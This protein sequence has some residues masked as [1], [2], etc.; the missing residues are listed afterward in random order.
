MIDVK[1]IIFWVYKVNI[2]FLKYSINNNTNIKHSFK[3]LLD[4]IHVSK[5]EY[6]SL[7]TNHIIQKYTIDIKNN[8]SD[9]S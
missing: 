4:V 6:C 3:L 2:Y 7:I 8:Y 5:V 1:E 9:H